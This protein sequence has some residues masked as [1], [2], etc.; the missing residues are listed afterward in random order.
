MGSGAAWGDF[1]GD[2]D[3]DLFVVAAGGP[4]TADPATW[5]PSRLYENRTE[6]GG[7]PRFV[8]VASFPE[9]RIVGMGA[10]WGD[11]DGDGWLDLVVTGYDALLLF[12]NDHGRLVRDETFP[13]LPTGQQ[14]YWAGA[15]WGDFDG[16]RDL[17]LYVSGYVRYVEDPNA[18]DQVSQ[19]YGH[20]V[21]YTLNPVSYEPER[22]LLFENRGP[23]PTEPRSTRWPPSSASTTPGG[24]ASAPS[25]TTSTTT[26]GSTSTWRTT[27]PTTPSSS[28]ASRR[29]GA[30]RTPDSPPGWRTTAA[31]WA[32]P[33][34]TTIG[35]A[36]TTCS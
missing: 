7:E 24:E 27:S 13:P 5:A 25:G 30:S 16:D 35:T 32:S 21:P 11:A 9:T 8:E 6:P 14:G 1:D 20:A 28:T 19:Q 4:L 34:A 18:R 31:P 33:P 15:A 2:G 17:D 36:T 29:T 26:A 22:N 3:D 12:H 10:A 23:G